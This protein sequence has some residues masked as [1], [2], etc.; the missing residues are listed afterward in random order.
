MSVVIGLFWC[1]A[2]VAVRLVITYINW[3]STKEKNSI[4]LD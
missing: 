3:A 4:Y 2:Y 1:I